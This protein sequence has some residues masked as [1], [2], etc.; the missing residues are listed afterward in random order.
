MDNGNS[1]PDFFTP[2]VGNTPYG[3]NPQDNIVDLNENIFSNAPDFLNAP[4]QQLG[5]AALQSFLPDQNRQS[6]ES[7]LESDNHLEAKQDLSGPAVAQPKSDGG[8]AKQ[9]PRILER[10]G[11]ITPKGRQVIEN[12]REKLWADGNAGTFYEEIANLRQ[13]ATQQQEGKAA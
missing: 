13:A 9:Y 4:S 6:I 12:A 3:E 7:E 5:G 8:E 1:S 11:D 2:G 10:D